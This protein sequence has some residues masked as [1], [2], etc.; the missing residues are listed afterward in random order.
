MTHWMLKWLTTSVWMTKTTSP[1]PG[2]NMLTTTTPHWMLNYWMLTWLTMTT[3]LWMTKT[4]MMA[5]RMKCS[6][7]S[8]SRR[9]ALRPVKLHSP[10]L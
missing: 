9:A 5:T 10:V 1:H 4:T 7:S 2:M 3:S 6:S 8:S